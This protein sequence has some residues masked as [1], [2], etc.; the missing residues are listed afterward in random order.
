MPVSAYITHNPSITL[1]K[2]IYK[3]H[4]DIQKVKKYFNTTD[5]KFKF[6]AETRET[7]NGPI[8]DVF[9]INNI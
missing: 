9:I 2:D 4:C 7:E 5:N 1:T 6:K 8:G 3:K